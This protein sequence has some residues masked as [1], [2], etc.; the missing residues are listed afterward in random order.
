VLGKEYEAQ[1]CSIAGA[2]EVL[3]ERWTLLIV[4]DAMYGVRR[5]SDFQAHLDVP[6]AILADRLRGLVQ[7]GILQR[8]PDPGHHGR[9]LYELT[10]AGRELWPVL[11][12]LLVWGAQHRR[13]NSRVFKHASCGTELNDNA[14]CPACNLTPDLAEIITEPQRGRRRLRHDPVAL[15][16]RSPHRMLEPVKTA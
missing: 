4:R 9:H 11:H 6:K 15:A 5:F 16:L 10:K 12:A 13:P 2:L 1:D 8:R 3:G 14:A 7:N